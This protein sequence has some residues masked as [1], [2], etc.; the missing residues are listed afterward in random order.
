MIPDVPFARITRSLVPTFVVALTALTFAP[1]AR[2]ADNGNPNQ[3]DRNP[4]FSAVIVI[5]DSLSDTGRTFSAIGIP[6]FP[7]YN[8]RPSNG[9]LWIENLAPRLRLTYQP[10]DN[11]SWAGA[12]TGRLNVFP[13]L[14]GMLDE[15]DELFASAPR[16]LDK[17]ALYVV[18]GGANDFIR[19]LGGE[20]PA[21]VIP[22]GV[23]NLVR[24]VTALHAAGADNIVVVD[25]PDMGLTPRAKALGAAASANATSLSAV[26]NGLLK[27]ALD[28][29]GFPTVRVNSFNLLNAFVSQ[30]AAFGFTNVT[31]PGISIFPASADTYLYWDDVHITTRAHRFV[32]DAVFNSLADAGL[33]K[34]LL[35]HP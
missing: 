3:P 27:T 35:K 31:T 32:S 5:G 7:Y 11:F 12:T 4:P 22:Q 10:L 24:I 17:K 23:A 1:S 21:V 30:P 15:T 8:G 13:G 28:N 16:R 34:Q 26:F 2:A 25:L 14:P 9:P 29:F 20:N 19:I 18:F 6:P 33:L